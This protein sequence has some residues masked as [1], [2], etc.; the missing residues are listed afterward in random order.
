M[1]KLFISVIKKN[2]LKLN[3][4]ILNFF[5]WKFPGIFQNFLSKK[6]GLFPGINRVFST[7]C[8]SIL[9]W[10]FGVVFLGLSFFEETCPVSGRKTCTVTEEWYLMLLLDHIVSALQDDAPTYTARDVKTFL[11]ESSNEDVV[12]NRGCKIQWSSRSPGLNPADFWLWG[13][14]KVSCVPGLINN[15]GGTEKCHSI[16]RRSHRCRHATFRWNGY[17]ERV[18]VAYYHVVVVMLSISCYKINCFALC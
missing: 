17:S 8:Y 18:S 12:I 15:T 2:V 11:L 9:V 6:S 14:L 13:V 4:S 5:T 7:L 16:D 10:L 3:F 1:W